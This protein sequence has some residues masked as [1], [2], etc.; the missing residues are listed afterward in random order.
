MSD[1]HTKEGSY[2]I[3]LNLSEDQV[4]QLTRLVEM[5][6]VINGNMDPR[7]RPETLDVLAHRAFLEEI[8]QILYKAIEDQHP[9]E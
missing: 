5:A 1:G 3:T 8:L 9:R 2:R 6:K 7:G 4:K